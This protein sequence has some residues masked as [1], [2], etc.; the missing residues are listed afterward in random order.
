MRVVD[1]VSFEI[2]AGETFGWVGE[3]GSGKTTLA[4]LLLRFEPATAGAVRFRQEDWLGLQGRALRERRRHMQ[5][6][7]QDAAAS[8]NPRRTAGQSVAE[9]L[10]AGGTLSPN[11]RK[12]AAAA[13][14]RDVGLPPAASARYPHEFSGGERQRIAI[15]R[16]VATRP[17]LIVCDEPLSALDVSVAAQIQNL[18]LDLQAQ[19]GVSYFFISHDVAAVARAA[20]RVGVM[21]AGR[22]V[23]EGPA[24]EVVARPL[25]PYTAALVARRTLPGERPDLAS[26]VPGCAFQPRC[27]IARPRCQEERPELLPV[28]PGRRAACFFPGE[29]AYSSKL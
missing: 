23:E 5:I 21:Y 2:A 27:P 7:F 3:S 17:S 1:R 20:D 25:H 9:P 11:D 10:E 26:P 15:A 19:M 18:L 13:L 6:V 24:A 12:E 14:L 29:I 22:L 8:L 4:R 28:E 16:A